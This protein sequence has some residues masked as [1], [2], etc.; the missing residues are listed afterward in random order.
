[1]IVET[2]LK[3]PDPRIELVQ[4]PKLHALL[5]HGLDCKLTVVSAPSGYGKTTLLGQWVENMNISPVWITF[6][7]EDNDSDHFWTLVATS[8]QQ[9]HSPFE[10]QTEF[11]YMRVEYRKMLVAALLNAFNH[12][13]RRV[14]MIWDDFHHITNLELLTEIIRFIRLLP[15]NVHLF[16]SSRSKPNL[17][18][19]RLR[20]E[21]ELNE[22]GQENLCFTR[23]ESDFFFNQ[24]YDLQLQPAQL[25]LLYKKT[26]GWITAMKLAAISLSGSKEPGN[27]IEGIIEK[28]MDLDEY[29]LDEIYIHLPG[30]IQQ[31]LCE[32]SI[33]EWMNGSMCTAVTG[34]EASPQILFEL[35]KSKLFVISL[36]NDEGWYRYHPLFRQFLLQQLKLREPHKLAELHLAA[37]TALEQA[38]SHKEAVDHYLSA[39]AYDQVIELLEHMS[40]HGE[41]LEWKDLRKW[42]AALPDRVLISKPRLCLIHIISLYFAGQLQEAKARL[43]WLIRTVDAQEG[44]FSEDVKLYLR[45]GIS[46]MQ[47][48]RA[49][50]DRDFAACLEFS[51]EY[52][53]RDPGGELVTEFESKWK[54][55]YPFKA[56]FGRIK[57]AEV[58]IKRML[59]V[60]SCTRAL[61][62]VG[63]LHIVYA[64]LMYEWNYLDKAMQHAREA[65]KLGGIRDSLELQAEAGL[66][67]T[68]IASAENSEALLTDANRQV[69]HILNR[70]IESRD[71]HPYRMEAIQ[72]YT[73]EYWL[74]LK[75]MSR[76][77]EWLLTNTKR[78]T[79]RIASIFIDQ[80]L[81]LAELLYRQHKWGEAEVLVRQIRELAREEEMKGEEI[82]CVIL[83]GLIRVQEGEGDRA[84]DLL[85]EALS[86][87][88][89][90][91][92]IRTFIDYG[93]IFR[94]HLEQYLQARR[95]HSREVV[96]EVSLP[97]VRRLLQHMRSGM[98]AG[99][100]EQ[101]VEA[102]QEQA[103]LTEKEVAVLRM[104]MA[105]LSNK[106]IGRQ[107]NITLSTVKTHVNN[108]YKKM[109]VSNRVL[110]VEEAKRRNLI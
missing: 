86:L 107:L 1:M 76:A 83:Q 81:L 61:R 68:R 12:I 43:E 55:S 28:S 23:E 59:D 93:P 78:P 24:C 54:G 101:T 35:E 63:S 51:R 22:I 3:V 25:T 98:E 97:Y 9:L 71:Q 62:L 104:I 82:R 74:I 66:L 48:M 40:F 99:G 90:E 77:E 57:Q 38:G 19:S 95:G 73:A 20:T 11:P 7:S 21:E 50:I 96:Y 14:V 18:L 4:R 45:K 42:L 94:R 47:V 70:F 17:Q 110:A 75:N 60:W 80:Y 102:H 56:I 64:K 32:T 39:C 31:F 53:E 67:M 89:P 29:Y 79:D 100:E 37:G 41:M 85:E 44:P 46:L 26:E 2:K 108:M 103:L 88:E 52:I 15:R 72:A 8:L 69:M 13:S 36:E 30:P 16:V 87:G 27:S 6:D 106:E 109:G 5:Q 65:M 58:L 92:Y 49:Y 33:L 91:G 84:F 10:F 105:G 34:F